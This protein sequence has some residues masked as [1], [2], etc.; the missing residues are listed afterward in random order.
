M[1]DDFF[2]AANYA[3]WFTEDARARHLTTIATL[4]EL[5]A[6]YSLAQLSLR[7]LLE[8][9]GVTAALVGTRNPRHARENAAT[10]H[11]SLSPHQLR[12]IEEIIRCA[13]RA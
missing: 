9:H 1:S 13:E 7:W 2:C 11:V 4:R 12:R 10:M 5:P 6:V 3:R 8:Q